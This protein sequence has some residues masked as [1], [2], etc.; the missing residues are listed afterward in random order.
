MPVTGPR[1]DTQAPGRHSR[2]AAAQPSQPCG[3]RWSC[4]PCCC[5][6]PAHPP[7][8]PVSSRPPNPRTA[9]RAYSQVPKLEETQSWWH[10]QIRPLTLAVLPGREVTALAVQP[11]AWE[12]GLQLLQKHPWP[13]AFCDSLL[14]GAL[15]ARG[16]EASPAPKGPPQDPLVVPFQAQ[17]PQGLGVDIRALAGD[18]RAPSPDPTPAPLRNQV[19]SLSHLCCFLSGPVPSTRPTE[20]ISLLLQAP[21]AGTGPASCCVA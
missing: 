18:R 14:K 20:T 10:W 15:L 6:S 3:A 5:C 11:A 9:C 16:P 4:R 2:A 12:A 8:L 13:P 19:L 7:P 1:A 21:E 17:Q